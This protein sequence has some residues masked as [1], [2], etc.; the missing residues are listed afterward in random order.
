VKRALLVVA[1]ACGGAQKPAGDASWLEG[2]FHSAQ[3]DAY[4]QTV[5]G[6]LWGVA[7]TEQGNFEVSHVDGTPRTL[8]AFTNGANPLRFPAE[9]ADGEHI[10]FAGTAGR[11]RF[12]RT[13]GGLRGDY[14]QPDGPTGSFEV[15]Q[16]ELPRVP[17][18]EQADLEFAADTAKDGAEGWARH[19]DEHGAMWRVDH[20][21][22]GAA[23]V[24]AMT[25]TLAAGALT[26]RPVTSG[27][28]GDLGFSFGTAE[29]TE[30]GGTPEHLTYCTIWK[31]EADG[32]W[33]VLFDIGRPAV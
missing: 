29:L 30:P 28:R 22:E 31:H 3:R 7:L 32:S 9:R 10:A 6:V 23:I 20:R 18:I 25:K 15:E 11:V 21:V 8:V 19:F 5:D 16:A 24:E 2:R 4:W 27:A 33:K 14:L 13:P 26:W 1:V 12:T 17:A